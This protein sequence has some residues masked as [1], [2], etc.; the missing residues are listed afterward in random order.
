M[1]KQILVLPGDGIGPEI[2]AEAVKVLELANDRF[3]LGFELAEDVIGGA[4]IDK[5]GVPLADQT[6][7]RARQADAVLLGAVG[8][9]KW[10]RIERDIRPERGLL[11]IRSQLGLFANLRPA[12]L[13]PATGRGLQP[14]A[15]S[16][17][18]A[19]H[20]HRPR[21]DR[22]HHLASPREQRVLENGERQAYDTLPYSESEIRRIARVGFDMARVRNNRLCSVDKAN[23]LA[24][25]QLWRE[26]VEEVA[27]DYPDV[28][29]SHMYVDN[30]A[31]QLVRAP[32]QFDV[33]VTDNIVRRHPVG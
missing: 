20:P 13:Y 8:G 19:G 23:V 22:R 6:L 2:M 21:T 9:P 7:Q 25:S 27:K 15:G 4:A 11:K 17:R 29:L 31:M 16:G 32:K 28:E 10:D 26:V 24:S 33:M 18:R 12:I 5:H 14:E 1:S 30:A 3:Q